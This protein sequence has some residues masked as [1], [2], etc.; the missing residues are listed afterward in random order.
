MTDST[1]YGLLA[2]T[3]LVVHF[4]F[5]V[6]VVVGFILILLGLF[7]GWPW[8]H[9]RKF[10]IAHMVAIGVVVLQAWFGQLCPLT[11]WE[12][13]LRRLAG[14]SGYTETFVEHWLHKVLFYQTEPWVFTM[15]YTV[16]GV[17]VV[18]VW[19]LGRRRIGKDD[20]Q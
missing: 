14:Q 19:L 4:A 12:N 15:I 16:F 5:V 18:L 9:N 3:I 1:L 7:A 10:R 17:L 20:D 2:D 11:T 6:F 8:V 13:E